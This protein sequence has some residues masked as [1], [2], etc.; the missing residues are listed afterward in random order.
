MYTNGLVNNDS[1]S[2]I[3]NASN[4]DNRSFSYDNSDK[5]YEWRY[6]ALIQAFLKLDFYS[7]K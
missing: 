7:Y 1:K 6:V 5:S 3:S 4:N 2:N